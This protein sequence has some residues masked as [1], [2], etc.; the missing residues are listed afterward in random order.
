MSVIP[1]PSQTTS[2]INGHRGRIRSLDGLRAFAVVLVFASHIDPGV[3]REGLVGVDVFF[4]LSGYL[5]TSLLLKEHTRRGSISLSRFYTRRMLRLYPALAVLV[6]VATVV[7]LVDHTARPIPDAL[8]ALLY[9]TDFWVQFH[10][11]TSLLAH[12]WSLS[13]EEQFYLIWPIALTVVLRRRWS[14]NAVL[15]A[16]IA[17]CIVVTAILGH[18]AGS[19][20]PIIAWMPTSQGPELAAGALLAVVQQSQGRTRIVRWLSSWPAATASIA[21]MVLLT[22]DLP[23]SWWVYGPMALVVWPLVAHLVLVPR[24]WLAEGFATRPMVW[25]GERSYGFYLIQIPVILLLDRSVHSVGV[26]LL[27]A[28]PITVV[29]TELS[30]RCV[31]Q[32]F[33]KMKSRFAT[34]G[35]SL[36]GDAEVEPRPL[37]L[38][39]LVQIDGSDPEMP[40]LDPSLQ[41]LR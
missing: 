13:V 2:A 34:P 24:G 38:P 35:V 4:V 18:Y 3:F 25:V 30:W 20:L 21:L 27:L 33:L 8:A 39:Y 40:S 26:L 6:V 37:P 14:I 1:E 23:D 16:T 28:L 11:G 5:I 29:L 22:V 31:E 15:T 7:A 9:V 19:H 10:P 36:T 17:G 12:T 32:P 41:T